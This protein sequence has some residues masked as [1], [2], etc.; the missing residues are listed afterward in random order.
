M[1]KEK[2]IK[3]GTEKVHEYLGRGWT[4]KLNTRTHSLGLCRPMER[5]IEI[6]VHTVEA[7]EEVFMETLLHEIAH[8]LDWI[9]NRAHGHGY[10]WKMIMI[11]LGLNPDRVASEQH[12]KAFSQSI[13]Y[14]YDIHCSNPDCDVHFNRMR[15]SRSASSWVCA[16][17]GSPFKWTQN[18]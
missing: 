18:Y 7:G 10:S 8:G 4:F 2:A 5:V 11:E 14:K 15:K 12:S 16:E 17:C 9:R 1:T 6:S 3:I 13:N